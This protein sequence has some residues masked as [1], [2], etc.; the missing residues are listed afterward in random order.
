MAL[1]IGLT[2]FAIFVYSQNGNFEADMSGN[3]V[4]IYIVPI[5]AALGYFS[6]QFIFRKQ[7]GSIKR[8]STLD[9]KLSRY[10]TASI[11]RYALIEAPAFLALIAYFLSGNALHLVIAIALLLYFFSLRPT[12]LKMMNQIPFTSEEEQQ[13]KN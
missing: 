10:Q 7:L 2:L 9:S 8:E 4:F 11:V 1:F 6:S 3:N 13:F 5:T 12:S